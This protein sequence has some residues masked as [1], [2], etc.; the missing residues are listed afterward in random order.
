MIKNYFFG[1]IYHRL[2]PQAASEDSDSPYNK[3]YNLL[4]PSK[5]GA[6]TFHIQRREPTPTENE[7]TTL[8]DHP[9]ILNL[10]QSAL[11]DT[12]IEWRKYAEDTN[13]IYGSS[14]P[15]LQA[16]LEL[17]EWLKNNVSSSDI[18]D[19]S[20]IVD[21]SARELILKRI[22]SLCVSISKHIE[23][24]RDDILFLACLTVAFRIFIERIKINH[25][26]LLTIDLVTEKDLLESLR[27]LKGVPP[28]IMREGDTYADTSGRKIIEYFMQDLQI[29][30]EKKSHPSFYDHMT[31][32]KIINK[33]VPLLKNRTFKLSFVDALYKDRVP[34]SFR[35]LY[36][37]SLIH[38]LSARGIGR[39][40][41]LCD[42]TG[43]W[44]GTLLGGVISNFNLKIMDNDP[45]LALEPRKRKMIDLFCR[46]FNIQSS[47]ELFKLTTKPIEDMTSHELM[48]NGNKF[49]LII[50]SPPF[51]NVEK[52][53]HDESQSFKRYPMLELWKK[54]FLVPFIQ[55]SANA[56]REGGCFCVQIS[57]N[58]ETKLLKPFVD[59][60]R[61]SN[62]FNDL[63]YYSYETQ[64]K[65]GLLDE[66]VSVERKSKVHPI[67][68]MC[69]F[70]KKA[71]LVRNSFV[72]LAANEEQSSTTPISVKQNF[73]DKGFSS[74]DLAKIKKI[75]METLSFI[76]EHYEELRELCSLRTV[77]IL[78]TECKECAHPTFRTLVLVYPTL[79]NLKL[80]AIEIIDIVNRGDGAATILMF[81]NANAKELSPYLKQILFLMLQKSKSFK[82]ILSNIE[83][84]VQ[85]GSFNISSLLIPTFSQV[86]ELTSPW[87]FENRTFEQTSTRDTEMDLAVVDAVRYDPTFFKSL[88]K[89]G[90]K[91]SLELQDNLAPEKRILGSQDNCMIV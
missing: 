82:F 26:I 20:T 4:Q 39:V 87:T 42:P 49:D 27:Y 89:R 16:S 15:T 65:Y 7:L 47:H 5:N 73:K 69:V 13:N 67:S 71:S 9:S 36:I 83:R 64:A 43:G 44:G 56:L 81:L 10:L 33:I 11:D 1:E 74:E 2:R 38:S 8:L 3:F 19:S 37:K 55:Q 77:D 70:Q 23:G 32:P 54:K 12:T 35:P 75:S 57:D 45:N 79:K 50:S 59:L 29:R 88:N 53:S 80:S 25:P 62:E 14:T 34:K 84:R 17:T 61:K 58:S 63:T 41:Y 76:D 18:R 68:L 46:A 48:F 22:L 91:R 90:V 86:Q 30:C 78:S 72:E 24:R 40:E 52:Y 60:V 21:L 6:V 51:F 31:S 66:L 28:K 85:D